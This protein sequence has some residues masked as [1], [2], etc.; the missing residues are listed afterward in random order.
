LVIGHG[1]FLLLLLSL[2]SSSPAREWK[3][4]ATGRTLEADILG[5]ECGRAAVVLASKKRLD[6]PIEKLS[7]ADREFLILWSAGKSPG[8]MLP[9]PLWPASVQQPAIV[10]KGGP[11]ADGTFIFRSAHYEFHCDAEVSVSV[12]ND[13]ATVAEGTIRLLHA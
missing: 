9:P 3:D 11:Q 1:S 7:D 4:A 8:E 12:M 10:V 6:I 13:F 2:P 5:I